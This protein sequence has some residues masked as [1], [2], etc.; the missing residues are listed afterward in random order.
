MKRSILFAVLL[1]CADN[2]SAGIDLDQYAFGWN[3]AP[4]LAIGSTSGQRLAQTFRAGLDGDLDHVD[5][6]LR[7]PRMAPA[8]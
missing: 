1:A 4:P 3:P 2:T 8:H 7:R 5:L 6:A